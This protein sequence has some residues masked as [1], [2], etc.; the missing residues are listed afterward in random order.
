[1]K[2]TILLL[3]AFFCSLMSYA[4]FD[5]AVGTEGCLAIERNSPLIV[6]WATGVHVTRGLQHDSETDFASFGCHYYAQGAPDGSATRA[7]SLGNAG[8][9]TITFD[10]PIV[11]REGFDFAVFENGF[12]ATFLELAFVEVSSNGIDFFRFPAVS[13][14]A[15]EADMAPTKIN[16]LAGKYEVGYGTPFELDD[17]EDNVL[18]NKRDIRFVRLVDVIGGEVIDS[19]GNIIYD[20]TSGGPSTGYDLTGVAV[21]NGAN[22]YMIADFEQ[23]L[24]ESNTHEIVSAENGTMGEDGNYYLT[25]TN[26]SLAFDAI[27]L[28]GGTFACGFG[29]S[30]HTNLATDQYY[31]SISLSGIEGPDSTYITGYY[32]DFAGTLE[33]NVIRQENDE[34]FFPKGVYVNNSVAA[35][36]H[37][38]S[39]AFPSNGWFSLTAI[40][41]NSNGD[42]TASSTIFLADYRIKN[43]VIKDW[44]WLDLT[45]LGECSKIIIKLNSNDD[46]GFGMN[47]PSYFC[48]DHF[49]YSLSEEQVVNTEVL[50]L[51][52]SNIE[53][54]SATLSAQIN[55]GSQEVI[56]KGF[57]WKV[58]SETDYIDTPVSSE[59]FSVALENLITNT[60]YT[61]R[62]YIVVEDEV[63]DTVFGAEM[64]FVTLDNS[65]VSEN[66][67]SKFTIYPNPSTG[68]VNVSVDIINENTQLMVYNV[69][70]KLVIS[71][72]MT[73][74]LKLDLSCLHKGIYIVKIVGDQQILV[75]KLIIQ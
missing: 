7:I 72:L 16:N 1:M 8:V 70:G 67:E 4:Q 32:S 23:M 73:N 55:A 25:Y 30:N 40:G 50:T 28:Y 22:P 12:N 41:Y 59:E 46:S 37:I 47:V 26:N 52:A 62:A 15:S 2:K 24:T 44:T 74:S 66:K 56:A 18:L 13:N 43:E 61:Y 33:H 58:F 45:A 71:H 75:Q 29:L 3:S 51:G 63:I 21:I 17:L 48:L 20:A 68:V 6:S 5:G 69:Q 53:T 36:N 27:G 65:L 31:T 38:I 14:A 9:A 39:S 19:E 57:Q 10:R 54:S 11:N 64:S 42:T 35:Y 60:E 34:P 49:V